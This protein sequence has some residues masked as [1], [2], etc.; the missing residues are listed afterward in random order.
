M[1]TKEQERE[2]LKKIKELIDSTGADSYIEAAF[3]GCVE[4]AEENITNDFLNSLK[5][6]ADKAYADK[7]KAEADNKT[8]IE[9]MNNMKTKIKDQEEIINQL[10]ILSSKLLDE[11]VHAENEVVTIQQEK[12]TE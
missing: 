3:D 12:F 8:I 9:E 11:K 2:V 7:L 5:E 6:R 1:M 4:L 10:N